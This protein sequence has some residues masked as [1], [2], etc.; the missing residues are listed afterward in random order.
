M[1]QLSLFEKPKVNL[2]PTVL[3]MLKQKDK[4]VIIES[5]AK[6]F[7]THCDKLKKQGCDS[8]SKSWWRFRFYEFLKCDEQSKTDAIWQEKT[9]KYHTFN[10]F[11]DMY[12]K[13]IIDERWHE[14][15]LLL[16]TNESQ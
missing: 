9:E 16:E 11:W 8:I 2:P 5:Y 12:W 3:S 7:I 4:A 13:L 1:P 10:D 15:G 6:G 14:K